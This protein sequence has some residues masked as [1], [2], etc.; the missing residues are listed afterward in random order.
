MNATPIDPRAFVSPH[1]LWGEM[2]RTDSRDPGILAAQESPPDEIRV[3]VS[4]LARELLEPDVRAVVGRTRVNSCYRSPLLNASI[5]GASRTSLHML[6]LAADLVPIDMPLV[7]AYEAIAA[8]RPWALDQLILEFGR[9]IHVGAPRPGTAPRHQLLMI[10]E[11]GQYLPWNPHDP[12][13]TALRRT[14]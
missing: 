5:P 10:F 9:W 13:V 8:R 11:A 3:N 1:Y 7:E 6:G 2:L 12:R 14:P 4:F